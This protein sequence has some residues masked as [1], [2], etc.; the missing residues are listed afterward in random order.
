MSTENPHNR[1]INKASDN[2]EDL[3]PVEAMLKA[4]GCLELH[5]S[6]QE[7]MAEHKDWRRCQT[8]V[9][10]FKKCIDKDRVQREGKRGQE[11]H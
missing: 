3:D 11:R 2:E 4:S 9:Q 1:S 7:C 6:V 10:D 5:Y 8:Q